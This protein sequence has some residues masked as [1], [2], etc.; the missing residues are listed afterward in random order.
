MWYGA[1]R[2]PTVFFVLIFFI[3]VIHS[4]VRSEAIEPDEESSGL[5]LDVL[6]RTYA[7]LIYFHPGE[8]YYPCSVEWYVQQ[9]SLWQ[10]AKHEKEKDKK[11]KS[12]GEI[13]QDQIATLGG[14]CEPQ[15]EYY[16]KPE[17]GSEHYRGQPI[18]NKKC[19]APC[20]AHAFKKAEGGIVLQYMFFYAYNGPTV[21]LKFVSFGVH[22]GD[23]EHID[24][25]LN[26]DYTIRDVFLSAHT[27][28]KAGNYV[29]PHKLRWHEK[30]HPI[31]FASRFGHASH[32][33]IMKFPD[34]NLDVTGKGVPWDTQYYIVNVDK[35]GQEWIY[36]RGSW[37]NSKTKLFLGQQREG[38]SP[39]TPY[40]QSWWRR[41]DHKAGVDAARVESVKTII[42]SK[43][44]KKNKT[45]QFL[46][47]VGSLGGLI[48]QTKKP[49]YSPVFS[50]DGAVPTRSKQLLVSIK[51]REIDQKQK[52]ISFSLYQERVGKSDALAY[53][54]VKD[55]TIL[56][57]PVFDKNKKTRVHDLKNLY[58]TDLEIEH[59][60]KKETAQFE[61]YFQP[62]ES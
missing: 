25:H 1:R 5:V 37:G 45:K 57:R 20:Y 12:K 15:A 23:W 36:F 21:D 59:S 39:K 29:S 42:S 4:A 35:P 60:T 49:H 50:I 47:K 17:V 46:S 27:A 31:I 8:K 32:K 48:K 9:C 44:R 51:N 34:K 11:I 43:A 52:L 62:L 3:G 56:T 26:P 13:T 30:T 2:G 28:Q 24:V 19:T 10:R 14:F 54:Q 58:V 33:K 38:G 55:G 6:M 41:G 61:V 53:K 16:L 22:Q 40:Y 18:I 7:P